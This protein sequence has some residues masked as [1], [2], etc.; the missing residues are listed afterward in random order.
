MNKKNTNLVKSGLIQVSWVS[1]L[2]RDLV[3]DAPVLT[4]IPRAPA[5]PEGPMG[6]CAPCEVRA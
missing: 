3:P 6:P 1:L 2:C 4:G 5:G